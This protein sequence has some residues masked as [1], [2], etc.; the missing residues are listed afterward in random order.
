MIIAAS[1][2][3][4]K[5]RKA[6]EDSYF[7]S[8]IIGENVVAC[9]ADGMGGHKGG[10]TASSMLCEYIETASYELDLFS[11]DSDKIV[12]L[13]EGVI[14]G[15]NEEIFLRAKSH[16]ELSGMGSTLVM[17]VASPE[18][19]VCANVGDS[20]MYQINDDGINQIT[21]D[22]SMVQEMV[23]K[24]QITPEEAMAHPNRNIITRAVG[25]DVE[26]KIDFF[27]LQ[28][29]KGDKLILCSDGLTNMVSEDDIYY[30][31]KNTHSPDEACEK[32]VNTANSAG[33]KDNITAVIIR[34]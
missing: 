17:C 11:K 9:V 3:V 25:S 4:G 30:I 29:K 16:E 7:V 27:K 18:R 23:D 32:L 34:L 24:G 2:D 20:R 12:E 1:S 21:K 14:E 19:V 33:G 22:H 10:K 8:D 5:M 28:P 6:N 31:V 15:A 13:L 26:L